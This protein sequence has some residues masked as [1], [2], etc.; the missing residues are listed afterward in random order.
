MSR[1]LVLL[2]L[3]LSP[4]CLITHVNGGDTN[5]AN[6]PDEKRAIQLRKEGIVQL[7]QLISETKPGSV[8]WAKLKFH[9][10]AFAMNDMERVREADV[11]DAYLRTIPVEVAKFRKI[12]ID[13]YLRMGKIKEAS[14]IAEKC[15]GWASD[16]ALLEQIK[17][18]G[19]DRGKFL[20]HIQDAGVSAVSYV[21][22]ME[23]SE[24]Q[25]LELVDRIASGN[26][27]PQIGWAKSLA[28][29]SIQ[30]R[31]VNFGDKST[32]ANASGSKK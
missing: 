14:I 13:A 30:N 4:R 5:P 1:L 3:L 21:P 18:G 23:G 27:S 7:E 32:I 20:R 10:N 6:A 24:E 8:E 31:S 12:Q 15:V 17:A 29:R 16:A 9:R 2:M 19:F 11:P 26:S 25:K 22:Q 28:N